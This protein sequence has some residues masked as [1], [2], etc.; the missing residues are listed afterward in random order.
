MY[1][2]I[3]NRRKLFL[4]RAADILGYA[5]FAPFKLLSLSRK[6]LNPRDIREVLIVRTAYI[7]D[8]VM[9][10]PILKPIK[11]TF[12][13]ARLTFLACSA[14]KDI[15]AANPHVDS[16]IAY[17][18]FW[19]YKKSGFSSYL[20][21]LNELRRKRFDLVIEARGDIRDIFLIAYLSRARHRISYGVGGGGFLL[22]DIVPFERV[23]HRVDYHLDIARRL[24]AGPGPID[25]GIMP[26]KTDFANAAALLSVDNPKHGPIVGIHAGGR[27]ALKRWGKEKYAALGR[28]LISRFNARVF[29]TGSTEDHPLIDAIIKETGKGAE[30]L[31]G[32]TDLPT[33]SALLKSLDVF[34]TNDS[35]VLHLASAM[36]CPCVAIFGPS[37]SNETGP[38]G[39]PFGRVVE[40]DFRC[41][42]TCDED[43]CLHSAHNECMSA[44]SVEDVLS[45]AVDV[46]KARQGGY[47][48]V[49]A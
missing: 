31:A 2:K 41:R 12:P 15:L 27:K 19:F 18:A 47:Y 25:W 20:R 28:E 48:G 34:I 8:V 13:N 3:I 9:T 11:N 35:S 33:L 1:Y 38:Y 26:G 45:A 46:L 40:K 42:Q 10:L 49:Q 32:K 7:G 21:L 39:N 24:G 17:D 30:N 22:T 5:A 16:V 14:A 44:I 6:P 29:F 23:K 43:K 37:K 36:K 4:T